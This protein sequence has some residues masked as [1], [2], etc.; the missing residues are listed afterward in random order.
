LFV[1]YYYFLTMQNDANIAMSRISML[2]RW[3]L[4]KRLGQ[5]RSFSII[6]LFRLFRASM[7]WQSGSC[8]K[9]RPLTVSKHVLVWVLR[10]VEMLSCPPPLL[11]TLWSAKHVKWMILA[12]DFTGSKEKVRL[13]E[14]WDLDSW[15]VVASPRA[16]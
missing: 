10:L 15:V 6:G 12:G 13:V 8:D 3:G 11:T 7:N 5:A 14:S 9:R 16:I 1:Y 4:L 2:A